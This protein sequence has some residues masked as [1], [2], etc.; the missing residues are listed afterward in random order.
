M[1]LTFHNTQ[2]LFFFLDLLLKIMSYRQGNITENNFT[3][4]NVQIQ[5]AKVGWVPNFVLENYW[6]FFKA[7]L[8]TSCSRLLPGVP[9]FD[10]SNVQQDEWIL[11]LVLYRF[12]KNVLSTKFTKLQ[13]KNGFVCSYRNLLQRSVVQSTEFNNKLNLQVHNSSELIELYL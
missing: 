9:K 11:L 3:P 12:V 7:K 5:L 10:S 6:Y 8:K 13:R 2:K 1:W 4:P